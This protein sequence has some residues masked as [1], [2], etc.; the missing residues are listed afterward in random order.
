VTRAASPRA[1]QLLPWLA[2]ASAAWLALF[3]ITSVDAYY[4]L[5][6]GRRI[7]D[8][9]AIPQRGVGSA[10]F[11]TAEWHDNEWG[12]QVVAALVGRTAR[13]PSGVLA[14]TPPGRAGLVILRAAAVAVTLALLAATMA[15]AGAPPLLSALSV[16]LA[17]FLT[18][19]NLF[20]DI[21]PQIA[22][23]AAL[24]ALGYLLERA[25]G[26]ARWAL[27][28]CAAV[29]AVW[30]NVHGAFVVGL[31]LLGCEAA[32]AW[33]E[34]RHDPGRRRRAWEVTATALGAPFAAFLN[35]LGVAQVVHP[36][37]YAARPEIYAANNEWAKPDLLHLPLL[38]AAVA[39]LVIALAAGARLRAALVLRVALFAGL[40]LTAIRHLPLLAIVLAPVLAIA[41]TDLMRRRGRTLP[42]SAWTRAAAGLAIAAGIVVLSGPRFI[43][44]V[45]RFEERP[46]RPLPE[47]HV[48]F[49]SKSGVPGNGFN[50]YRFG[51]FLMF[52]QYPAERVFMDGRNDLY[53][54]FRARVFDPI[55]SCAPGWEAL[56]ADARARYDVRWVLIDGAEPLA[57]ALDRDPAWR[58]VADEEL[59]GDDR[60]GPDGIV[61]FLE[62][63]R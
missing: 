3:P 42:E 5:A 7:L 27:P 12:F 35:P 16:W 62:D 20:W 33:W 55:L 59:R 2:V 25:R 45:P 19:G 57:A 54:A 26:R 22:S 37:L 47:A 30:A 60:F 15:R 31:G 29:I 8:E 18:F 6:T 13:E 4:H 23:Y 40:F 46:S 63:R 49:L 28:A 24:A 61:L 53:G 58:R 9:R 10:T 17:A 48:R 1:A 56:W 32:G 36:F 11:G 38:V 14:L 44:P 34:A 43:G 21:R 50:S 51:G 52:R 39:L 41:L